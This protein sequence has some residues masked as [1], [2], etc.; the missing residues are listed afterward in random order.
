MKSSLIKGSL[1]GS[2]FTVLALN[3]NAQKITDN[4]LKVNI[5]EI[6][7]PITQLKE[8]EPISFSY[9][10]DKQKNLKLPLGSQYGFATKSVSTNFP[11]VVYETS[12]MYSAG[13]NQFK[14]AK[15]DEVNMEKLIPVLVAAI[16]EQQAQID[17]LKREIEALKKK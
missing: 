6:T 13:K 10:V 4:E 17:V 16:N 9:N 15:Y 8:L 1:L 3:V 14:T 2:I 12:K 5:A 11:S 7:N